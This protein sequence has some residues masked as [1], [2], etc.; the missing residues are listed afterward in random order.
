MGGA[1]WRGFV[2][3]MGKPVKIMDFTKKMIAI[4]IMPG[5]Y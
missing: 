4:W 3:D 5:G 1:R 2:F